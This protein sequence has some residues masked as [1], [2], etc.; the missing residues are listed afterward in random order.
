LC[1]IDLIGLINSSALAVLH[2]CLCSHWFT[3]IAQPNNKGTQKQAIETMEVIF[4]YIAERYL[5]T[6]TLPPAPAIPPLPAA[7]PVAKTSS[8]L[9]STCAFQCPTTATSSMIRKCTAK[10]ELIDE[11]DHYLRFDTA[12]I[13]EQEWDEN[14]QSNEPSREEVLLNPLLWWKIHAMEFPTI[15]WMA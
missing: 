13:S 14:T 2:P 6:L 9:A 5:E 12:P 15:A 11:L 4:R 3:S 8:F 7:K 1:L 10:E